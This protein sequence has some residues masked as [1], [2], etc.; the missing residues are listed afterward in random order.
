M[1]D[2][3][4]ERRPRFSLAEIP[5]PIGFHV[6]PTGLV[7]PAPVVETPG[8]LDGHIQHLSASSLRLLKVCPEAW[9]RRY[10]KHEKE[11]P[12]EALTVGSATHAAVG[13][14]QIEKIKTGEDLPVSTVVEYFHDKA[15]P[16]AVEDD[17]GV[18]E[19]RWD[20]K[21]EEVRRD[22]ERMT[23]AYQGEVSP[24]IQ[25]LAVEQ[26][27][28]LSVEGVPVPIIG[29][30][31]FV[32]ER[33]VIDLKTGK[34]V[35]RKPDANWRFQATIY[36]L[37]TEKAVHFHSV[38]RAQTPSIATPLSDPEMLL[39]FRPDLVE[40]TATTLR[41]YAGMIEYY[42]HRYGPDET[43]PLTG[44]VSDYKGGAACNYCGYRPTCPAWAWERQPMTL[45]E[46]H[47]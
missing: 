10:I 4:D 27:I 44:L 1:S 23:Q 20:K 28:S 14:N 32:E 9:R 29:Y 47:P 16:E 6:E 2:N 46:V 21:P 25:P 34:Q 7:V 37:A 41:D 43:W 36:S 22:G 18:E 26:K 11:R 38:S 15:W 33:D 5:A 19:I 45:L 40:V 8:W 42:M 24:R 35:S 30:L 12:G 3:G 31:D 17:G 39:P 13:F